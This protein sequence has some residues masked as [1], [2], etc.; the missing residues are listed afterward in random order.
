MWALLQTSQREVHLLSSTP[1]SSTF[2]SID[3]D[4]TGELSVIVPDDDQ[5]W[6]Y[7]LE[8]TTLAAVA[9]RAGHTIQ[10]TSSGVYAIVDGKRESEWRSDENI[11]AATVGET[12]EVILIA[13]RCGEQSEI[14]PISCRTENGLASL[15]RLDGG[16]IFHGE[17]TSI[18]DVTITYGALRAVVCTSNGEVLVSS[19]AYPGPPILASLP[20]VSSAD[21]SFTCDSIVIQQTYSTDDATISLLCGLRNGTVCMLSLETTSKGMP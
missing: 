6:G 19:L 4:N 20:L 14:I 9:P 3:V 2:I 1:N 7:D 13:V 15:V 21:P 18:A 5:D 16:Q 8:H 10:V 17:V 12:G 11:I